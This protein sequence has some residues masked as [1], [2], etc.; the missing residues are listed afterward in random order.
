MVGE[1]PDEARADEAGT[2]RSSI[3]GDGTYLVTGGLGAL[4]LQLAQWLIERGAGHVV[5]MSRR[6]PSEEVAA[7]LERLRATGAA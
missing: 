5:L 2:D 6:A 7:E 1:R 3:R 4:G